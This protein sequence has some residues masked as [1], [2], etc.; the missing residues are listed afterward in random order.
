VTADELTA[1][2]D[3]LIDYAK[4]DRIVEDW[5][6]E[7]CRRVFAAAGI[8]LTERQFEAAAKSFRQLPF[9]GG[10]YTAD[11]KRLLKAIVTTSTK[12]NNE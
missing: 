4:T 2:R 1:L 12:E 6:P 3:A 7:A 8:A 11:A 10:S 5:T 9:R